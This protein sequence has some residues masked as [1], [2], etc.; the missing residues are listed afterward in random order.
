[1]TNKTPIVYLVVG[2]LGSAKELLP[3]SVELEKRGIVVKWFADAQGKAGT[4]ILTKKN[5]VFEGRVPTFD[6]K[7]NLILAGTSA[8][9]NGLQLAWTAFGRERGIPTGWLEDL[10]GTGER[11]NSREVDP[12]FMLVNDEVAAQIAKNIRPN[13]ATIV[14]GKA[15]FENLVP[16]I[17]NVKAIRERTRQALNVALSDKLITYWSGGE[18]PDRVSVHLEALSESLLG[19]TP[20][21]AVRLHP[22]LSEQFRNEQMA[23]LRETKVKL[24]DANAVVPVELNIASNV[25][26]ADWSGTE[27]YG[28]MLV[29]TPTI[30]TMFPYD[31]D[32]LEAAGYTDGVPPMLSVDAA[33]GPESADELENDIL[34][35]FDD[36]E[37]VHHT[38]NKNRESFMPILNPGATSR[39]TDAVIA[40]LIN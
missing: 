28:S 23:K 9:A 32:R 38:L 15:S 10:W 39:I 5:I 22:K 20:Y 1:M 7:P 36:E 12:D 18:K 37:A 17:Q 2:D 14:V 13:L 40:Q 21:L 26:M 27:G 11:L 25:V 4:D 16:L 33:L 3:V 19:R 30:I 6:D 35:I 29:G 34:K 31:K 24:I 8:S